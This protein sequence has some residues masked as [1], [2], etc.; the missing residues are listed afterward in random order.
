MICSENVDTS[1][2]NF[3]KLVEDTRI[4]LNNDAQS[5]MNSYRSKT[6]Q[7]LEPVV[8]E[9]MELAAK[10]TAFENSIILVS[11]HTFPDIVTKVNENRYF[12]VEVKSTTKDHWQ[13]IGN[14]VLESCRYDNLDRIFLMFGKLGGKNV[15]FRA[16][17][18][19]DCLSEVRVT[20][21]PRYYIDMELG[22]N[23]TIFDKIKQPYDDVRKLEN[24]V[25]PFAEYYRTQ[26]SQ[27]ESLWWLGDNADESTD[28]KVRLWNTI[29]GERQDE[30]VA[31]AMAWFPE[32]ITGETS[33]KYGRYVL[34]LVTSFGIVSPNVRDNF[35]AGGR[36]TFTV[37]GNT[38]EGIPRIFKRVK[39]LRDRIFEEIYY[40][41]DFTIHE[42]WKVKSMRPDDR[43]NR[44]IEL[45]SDINPIIRGIS[46]K[47][48]VSEL[49]RDIFANDT[50]VDYSI[51][52]N[53]LVADWHKHHY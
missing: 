28:I 4:L 34:W 43:L 31:K 46:G 6:A 20:H 52:D 23:E 48:Y 5:N 12:G 7:K 30:L 33:Q 2:N 26:L 16:R 22:K 32:T 24:P 42:F 3:R 25:K 36:V 37:S 1:L 9:K 13:S 40:A 19:E 27:G 35:S 10:G 47:Y 18:Y 14:S 38:Y 11:G 39:E 41:D 21:Y 49:L 44:W 8:K 45:V 15:E 17:P 53:Q 29:S 50:V 51:D